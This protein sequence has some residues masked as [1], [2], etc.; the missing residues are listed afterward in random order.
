MCPFAI[1]TVLCSGPVPTL[2][3]SPERPIT[4][5]REICFAESIRVAEFSADCG[6]RQSLQ[7]RAARASDRDRER[8]QRRIFLRVSELR[9]ITRHYRSHRQRQRNERGAV[10]LGLI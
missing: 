7:A 9:R 5:P 3:F 2:N 6:R 4:S 8:I 10:A 1:R